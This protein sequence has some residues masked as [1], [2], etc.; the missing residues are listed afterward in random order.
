[1]EGFVKLNALLATMAAS[2]FLVRYVFLRAMIA[3]MRQTV[4]TVFRV[5]FFI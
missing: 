3:L 5:T 4:S 2:A 1:M